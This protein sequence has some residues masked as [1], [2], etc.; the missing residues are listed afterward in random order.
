VTHLELCGRLEDLTHRLVQYMANPPQA[1]E[2]RKLGSTKKLLVAQRDGK[3]VVQCLAKAFPITQ[4]FVWLEASK[5][6]GLELR[7]VSAEDD[8]DD[9]KLAGLIVRQDGKALL[10]GPDSDF[11]R[12]LASDDDMGSTGIAVL[13]AVGARVLMALP[14]RHY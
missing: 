5:T 13:E 7:V 14:K 6:L 8:S 4:S 3:H 10:I 2:L 12:S 1:S 11:K 9:L